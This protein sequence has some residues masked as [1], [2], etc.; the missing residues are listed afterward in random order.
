ML[1]ITRNWKTE[2]IAV[3][4]L[5]LWDENARFPEEYFAKKEDEL[6]AYFLKKKEFK[7]EE[8]AKEV[9]RDFD[10]PQ[11]EKLVVLR[12]NGKSIVL[13]GNRRLVVYKLLLNPTLSKE[14]HIK[15]FFIKLKK[16]VVIN[17]QYRLEASVTS[18]KKEG[19]RFV[20]R[21]H[22]KGNNEVNWGE[23]E[24]RNFVVRSSGGKHLDI[25]RTKLA[26]VVKSLN[27]PNEIIEAILGRGYVTTLYRILDNLSAQKKLGYTFS[28]SGELFVREQKKFDN[29]LR[30]IVFNIWNKTDFDGRPVDSRFLNKK[31]SID[32]YLQKIHERD[33][34]K[35]DSQIKK[36][37]SVD[38][39]GKKTII[40]KFNRS[41]ELSGVRS[42]LINSIIY[43]NSN[44]V[45][46]IYDELRKKLK[47]DDVPNAVAVLF[48]VFLE[49][50]IDC[51]IE[52]KKIITPENIKLSG[53]INLVIKD[54]KQKKLA[55]DKQLKNIAKV[56]QQDNTSVLSIKT[57]HDFVHDYRSSPIPTEL[58]KYWDNLNEFFVIL[59][60]A[61]K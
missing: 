32:I 28:S 52:K 19:L 47:V 5:S 8:F 9:V 10:L 35:V 54:L 57:F 26:N 25:R 11:L 41:K 36:Q 56:A 55:D 24:R 17:D 49:S 3:L 20:D 16:Q 12:M 18:L 2:N 59:W 15:I 4:N 45:N 44:R 7:I 60:G 37:T 58:K 61:L 29:L 13:E 53:K 50:S 14:K 39:Q 40:N 33:I 48:R 42:H 23:L 31:D 22:N 21:K 43:I 34:D 1:R 51:Y 46:D 30:I 38:L 6:I 27:L